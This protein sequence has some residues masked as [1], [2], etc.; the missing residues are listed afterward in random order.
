MT[1]RI[2]ARIFKATMM[3]IFC[4]LFI[5]VG[6][7]TLVL[8]RPN[9]KAGLR[10]AQAWLFHNAEDGCDIMLPSMKGNFCMARDPD[11]KIFYT[12][13]DYKIYIK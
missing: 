1:Y 7:T 6:L 13:K 11:G 8:F 3:L 10:T 12:N 2:L 4:V 9:I 5:G